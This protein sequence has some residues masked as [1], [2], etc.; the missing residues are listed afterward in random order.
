[1]RHAK[2]ALSTEEDL[3][4]SKEKYARMIQASPDAITPRSLPGRRYQEVND[5]F[6]RMT[7]YPPEEVL[8]QTSAELNVWADPEQRRA[9]IEKILPEGEI[10]KEEFRFRTKS[11]EIRFGQLAAV[12]IMIGDQPCR[13]SVR[14]DIT[15]RKQAEEQLRRSKGN[16]RSLV[17]DADF[18]ILQ[19]T[20]GNQRSFAGWVTISR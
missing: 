20:Q 1:L 10:Q 4:Q 18:G 6:C 7:G 14:R 8:G 11:G 12:R 17:Q 16:F 2:F 5:G 13:L 9:T 19:A 3:R 15:R